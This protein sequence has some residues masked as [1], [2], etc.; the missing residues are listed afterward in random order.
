MA[1]AAARSILVARRGGALIPWGAPFSSLDVAGALG[2]QRELRAQ[3]R[4]ERIHPNTGPDRNNDP[5][6]PTTV[7]VEQPWHEI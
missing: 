5:T 7:F 3:C 6:L 4:G 2:V 1:Q